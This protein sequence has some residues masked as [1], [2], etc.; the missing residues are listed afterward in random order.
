MAENMAAE[1]PIS[2][3]GKFNNYEFNSDAYIEPSTGFP[4]GGVNGWPGMLFAC[5]VGNS[6]KGIAYQSYTDGHTAFGDYPNGTGAKRLKDFFYPNENRPCHLYVI[7]ADGTEVNGTGSTIYSDNQQ[8]TTNGYHSTSRFARDDGAWGL[9]IDLER[10][11]G[12]GGGYLRDNAANGYGCENRNSGDSNA[13]VAYWG[14]SNNSTT[15]C[16]YFCI[17]LTE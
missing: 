14:G 7:N 9:A 13:N 11:D 15:Y 1:N 17:K 16:F 2:S 12:N 3:I 5:F 8:P 6:Y 10:L 4:S